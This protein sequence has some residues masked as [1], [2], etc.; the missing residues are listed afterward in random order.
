MP[1]AFIGSRRPGPGHIRRSFQIGTAHVWIALKSSGRHYHAAPRFD[2]NLLPVFFDDGAR[3]LTFGFDQSGH[4]GF[5]PYRN[6]AVHGCLEQ[7]PEQSIA[8]GQ[9]SVPFGFHPHRQINCV[10]NFLL[11]QNPKP[12]FGFGDDF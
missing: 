5:S 9:P 10:K 1:I 11:H 12:A 3:D 8:T 4:A 7:S 2:L 6:I